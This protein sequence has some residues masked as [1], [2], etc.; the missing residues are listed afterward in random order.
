MTPTAKPEP[1]KSD[2]EEFEEGA[3]LMMD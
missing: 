2:L 1:P 3:A